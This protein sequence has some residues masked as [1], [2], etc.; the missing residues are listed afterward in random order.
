M[1]TVVD[2]GNPF[3]VAKMTEIEEMEGLSCIVP[4]LD[5]LESAEGDASHHLLLRHGKH[6]DV[7]DE[8]VAELVVEFPFNLFPFLLR[9]IRE[10]R[11]QVLSHH[12]GAIEP[13]Y[14]QAAEIGKSIKNGKRQ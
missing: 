9:L 7:L 8:V 13:P 10:S 6:L 4:F 1:Q 14:E 5:F 12:L 11:A 2:G 3:P